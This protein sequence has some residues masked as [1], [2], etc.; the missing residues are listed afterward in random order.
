MALDPYA[1]RIKEKDLPRDAKIMYL[2]KYAARNHLC[3]ESKNDIPCSYPG[4]KH[5]TKIENAKDGE[6]LFVREGETK[7]YWEVE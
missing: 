1:R 2:C 3:P 6:R 7:Y 5:T 4:C